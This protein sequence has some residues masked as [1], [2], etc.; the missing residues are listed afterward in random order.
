MLT[1]EGNP[2]GNLLIFWGRALGPGRACGQP[3]VGHKFTTEMAVPHAPSAAQTAGRGDGGNQPGESTFSRVLRL[4][5]MYFFVN[6]LMKGIFQQMGKPQEGQVGQHVNIMHTNAWPVGQK[7][8]VSVFLSASD[9]L[10]RMAETVGNDRALVFHESNVLYSWEGNTVD[11]FSRNVT[12]PTNL[13][14]HLLKNHSVYAHVLIQ[15]SESMGFF[16]SESEPPCTP[17]DCIEAHYR[18]NTYKEA[19]KLHARKRLL[20]GEYTDTRVTSIEDVETSKNSPAILVNWWRPS[21]VVRLMLDHTTYQV[22]GI[23]RDFAQGYTMIPGRHEYAPTVYFDNF[24]SLSSKHIQLNDTLSSLPLE[25]SF[26]FVSLLKWK[27]QS[28][29]EE[30]WKRQQAIGTQKEGDAEEMK[31]MMLETNPV[32]LG[33]TFMVTLLHMIFDCLVGQT[34][35]SSTSRIFIVF[36]M[37]HFLVFSRT[38]YINIAYQI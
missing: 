17:M 2:I 35:S 22:N 20:S 28:Q 9:T 31:R 10:E 1:L 34:R 37:V 38:E 19:P 18:I 27:F 26:S 5:V 12:V 25:I 13:F 36:S 3:Q 23:P 4:M 15:K 24:W 32:L 11:T 6:M 29:M 7:L 16:G 21:L 33:V 30:S 8:N 14:D